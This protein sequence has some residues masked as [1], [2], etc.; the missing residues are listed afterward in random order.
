MRKLYPTSHILTT[1]WGFLAG[2]WDL[3]VCP[4]RDPSGS[5]CV[6]PSWPSLLTPVSP[7]L[8]LWGWRD[9]QNQELWRTSTFQRLEALGPRWKGAYPLAQ[10]PEPQEV[11]ALKEHSAEQEGNS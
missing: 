2:V 7:T 8:S 3:R 9:G 1:A 10:T 11:G 5:S 6:Q 4:G